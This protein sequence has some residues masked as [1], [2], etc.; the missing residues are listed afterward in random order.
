MLAQDRTESN[1]EPINHGK[2]I[3]RFPPDAIKS[4]RWLE[5]IN[6]KICRQLMSILFNQ[7]YFNEEMLPK[8][9]HT[10]THTHTHIYIY[11]YVTPGKIY[12][13]TTPRKYFFYYFNLWNINSAQISDKISF[14]QE[15]N[16]LATGN[17]FQTNLNILF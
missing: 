11:I 3:N 16:Y 1:W 14:T 12:G 4:M 7:M 8:Y 9:T 15:P 13:H 17:I 5:R 10:H 6:T 2:F